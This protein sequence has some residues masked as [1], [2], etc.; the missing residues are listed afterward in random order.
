MIFDRLESVRPQ[1]PK[2]W[3]LH[4]ME[5]PLCVDGAL[6]PDTS[7]HPDGHFL[8][9]GRTLRA[10]HG[11][12]VLFSKTVLPEKAVLRVLGGRGH[13]FEVNGE[14]FDMNDLWW[15]K[16]GTKEYQ[17]RI[18]LGGWRAEVEP[19]ARQ[20]EDLFLHVLWATDDSVKEMFPVERVGPAGVRFTADG[21][22]VEA[23]FAPTG[24]VGGRIKLTRGGKV[25]ADRPLAEGVED[26]YRKWASDPRHREWM[27]SD[28]L[29]AVIGEAEVD[30]WRKEH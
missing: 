1:D 18:G 12:S 21:T 26:D 25:I 20:A 27:T 15:Q 28:F 23:T 16:V 14:N 7:V 4:T 3:Y 30:A 5:Q 29:R 10:P 19:E 6:R 24:P 8:A 11:G 17:E 2:R 13:Q 22:A 9:S